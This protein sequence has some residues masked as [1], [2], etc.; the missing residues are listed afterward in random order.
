MK[1]LTT[2]LGLLL[3]SGG[4]A[5]CVADAGPYGSSGYAYSSGYDQT[6]PGSYSGGSVYAP[7]TYYNSG[8]GQAYPR[9]YGGGSVYAPPTTY[10]YA[11]RPAYYA[12]PRAV[13]YGPPTVGLGVTVR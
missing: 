8:Y 4:L 13:Y 1:T 10:Y 7:P 6:Y 12:P 2:V 9:S 3:L 5:A 11:P